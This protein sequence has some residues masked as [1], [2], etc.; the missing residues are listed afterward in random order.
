MTFLNSIFLWGAL[1]ASVPILIHLFSR[2]KKV[3]IPWGAMQFL[4]EKPPRRKAKF[5]K[6]NELILLLLRILAIIL[7]ALAFARP[8]VS[9]FGGGQ[10]KRDFIFIIDASLSSSLSGPDGK[11]FFDQQRELVVETIETLSSDDY[12]RVLVSANSQRWLSDTPLAMDKEKRN[13]LIAEINLLEPTSGATDFPL[14]I[15][16][17]LALPAAEEGLPRQIS[18]FADG[19]ANGWQA[20]E[21]TVWLAT[22]RF[23]KEAPTATY[24][25]VLFAGESLPKGENLL[26]ENIDLEREF[27]APGSPMT[28]RA[29]I[30]NTSTYPSPACNAVWQL[31]EKTHSYVPIPALSP[32]QATTVP[33]QFT[34]P[35]GG[36]HALSVQIREKDIFLQD[37]Q[38]DTVFEVIDEIPVLV[39]DG[40]FEE[41]TLDFLESGYFLSAIG[42]NPGK[43]NQPKNSSIFQP[44]VI[45]PEALARQN[46]S[47]YFCVI[48]ANT[49]ALTAEEAEQLEDFVRAGGGLWIALGD[50]IEPAGHQETMSQLSSAALLGP[51]EKLSDED[52]IGVRPPLE[53]DSPVAL[54][55]D[56]ERLDT[57]R[58][59]ATQFHRFKTPLPS[60]V[61]VPLSFEGGDPLL[62]E[63]SLG[64]GRIAISSLPLNLRWSNLPLTQSYVVLVHELLWH[65]LEPQLTK[66][67]LPPGAPFRWR[68]PPSLVGES[69]TLV[70][71]DEKTTPLKSLSDEVLLN[72]T[73]DPGLYSITSPLMEERSLVQYFH[74]SQPSAESEI[75]LLSEAEKTTLAETGGLT[76]TD[77]PLQSAPE[78]LAE[79][80]PKN[81]FWAILLL[82]LLGLFL[83]EA[84]LA[85]R[86][87][88][89]KRTKRVAATA[90]PLHR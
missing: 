23:I 55:G 35:E 62:I 51:I 16:E 61:S 42:Y 36:V 57:D 52:S 27:A 67:N 1:A 45:A 43:R 10:A 26:V 81:P 28:A 11:V 18:I 84:F 82:A 69:A 33:L 71:P 2:K 77:A 32:G 54:L 56:L 20:G 76:L 66:R 9:L 19:L 37:N 15:Q 6:L 41:G 40:N 50:Q 4:M 70:K 58:I 39:V 83:L 78:S 38:S 12:L 3:V 47:A 90:T 25:E 34:A 22:Q 79:A 64:S 5:L 13:A 86:L 31:G 68:P 14:A 63:Q 30:R 80:R 29:S 87:L 8:L 60:G 88:R 46:L 72:Q 89:L 85:H 73:S 75:R 49:R 7:L 59:R 48:L 21:S 65:L 17:A 44:K 74:I 24:I 53:D